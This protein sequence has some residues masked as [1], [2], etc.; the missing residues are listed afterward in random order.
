MENIIINKNKY[1]IYNDKAE[2]LVLKKENRIF[3]PSII[4][5]QSPDSYDEIIKYIIDLLKSKSE[6]VYLGKVIEEFPIF[7]TQNGKLKKVIL[8]ETKNYFSCYSENIRDFNFEIMK[9][10]Y[11]EGI[12][13]DLILME[14]LKQIIENRFKNRI[15]IDKYLLQPLDELDKKLSLK[16]Y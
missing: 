12:I 8:Q 16:N 11:K 7:K 10:Y 4:D 5:E 6:L 15:K 13:P 3:I 1:I 2:I 14:E 9:L